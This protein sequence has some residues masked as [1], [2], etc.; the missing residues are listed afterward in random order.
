VFGVKKQE[1]PRIISYMERVG[2]G[3]AA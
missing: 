1:I 2:V 3:R